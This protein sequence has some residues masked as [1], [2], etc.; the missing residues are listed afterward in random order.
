VPEVLDD[1]PDLSDLRG[2]I[3]PASLHPEPPRS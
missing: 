1:G 3:G 2:G